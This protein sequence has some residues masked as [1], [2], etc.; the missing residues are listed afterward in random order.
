ME[1]QMN[2]DSFLV[3]IDFKKA[4]DS[5][6]M[7]FLYRVMQKMGIPLKFISMIKAMDSNVFAKV[8]INGAKSKKN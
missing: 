6:D 8:M 5:I 3:R 1:E 7:G 2:S 4:F